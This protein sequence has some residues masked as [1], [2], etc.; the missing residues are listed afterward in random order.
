MHREIAMKFPYWYLL[1][2]PISLYYIGA[3]LNLFV[4]AINHGQMPVQIAYALQAATEFDDRHTF[5]TAATHLKFLCDWINLG[6]GIA[7][8]GD[9]LLWL[10][11]ATTNLGAAVWAAL[12]IRDRNKR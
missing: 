4:M 2:T 1:V 9:V 7:S 11:Q 6:D 3:F 5:M 8:P 12:M 10:G